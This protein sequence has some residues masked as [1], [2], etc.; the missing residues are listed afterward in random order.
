MTYPASP[1]QR[2]HSTTKKLLK[3]TSLVGN[4]S[5]E[6]DS[7]FGHSAT[8]SNLHQGTVSVS[9]DQ[10]LGSEK[11]TPTHIQR[12]PMSIRDQY[13]QK[14]RKDPENVNI[15]QKRKRSSQKEESLAGNAENSCSKF[16][17]K[18][19]SK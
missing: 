19:G 15:P 11:C 2:Q 7:R 14:R 8:S 10:T 12:T 3:K 16:P 13:N 9:E 4:S 6:K 1:N 17:L 18:E 5:A